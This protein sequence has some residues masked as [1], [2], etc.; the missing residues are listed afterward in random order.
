MIKNALLA[1]KMD[2]LNKERATLVEEKRQLELNIK[3]LGITKNAAYSV[4]H[5][6]P[7][8]TI[9]LRDEWV[10]KKIAIDKEVER[11]NAEIKI[12]HRQQEVDKNI[13]VGKILREIFND[14]QMEEIKEEAK[15]RVDPEYK[16]QKMSFSIADC[17]DV[18]N[19]MYQYRKVA[20]NQLETMI[21]FRLTLTKIIEEG[22]DKFGQGEFLKFISPLNQ[23]II[24]IKELEKIKREHFL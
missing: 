13:G 8:E 15:K 16:H 20:Q 6:I 4:R 12:I 7:Q 11:L 1:N 5:K 3:S 22:C 10:K 2:S 19:R 23:L 17:A 9:L 14:D 18:K 21:K 24:P